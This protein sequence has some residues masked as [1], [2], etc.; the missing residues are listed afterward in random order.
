MGQQTESDLRCKDGI[1]GDAESDSGAALLQTA[2]AREKTML[3]EEGEQEGGAKIKANSTDEG[4]VADE[5]DVAA[6]DGKIPT[7][8]IKL[9]GNGKWFCALSTKGSGTKC[10]FW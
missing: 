1:E 9:Q 5:A 4:D 10:G 7:G 3:E 8:Q 2:T 6:L